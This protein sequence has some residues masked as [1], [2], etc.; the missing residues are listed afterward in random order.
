[1][2]RRR[3][4]LEILRDILKNCKEPSQITH[5]TRLANL[6]FYS[7][8]EYVDPLVSKGYLEQRPRGIKDHRT[9]WEWRTTEKGR[10]LLKEINGVYGKIMV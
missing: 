9:F 6:Q 1:M 5:I 3:D 10:E 8:H 7:F 2:T 4:K